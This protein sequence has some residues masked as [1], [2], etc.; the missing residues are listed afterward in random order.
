MN[1][2]WVL[3]ESAGKFSLYTCELGAITLCAHRDG[4]WAIVDTATMKKIIL[5]GRGKER[6]LDA[7]KEAVGSVVVRILADIAE[8]L[9]AVLSWENEA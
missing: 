1:L 6:T 9:G 8:G 5:H 2:H 4:L 7:A 3:R